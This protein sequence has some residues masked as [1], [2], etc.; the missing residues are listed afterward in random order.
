MQQLEMHRIGRFSL[1]VARR[2]WFDALLKEVLRHD[3]GELIRMALLIGNPANELVLLR[4][5]EFGLSRKR[6]DLGKGSDN[7]RKQKQP[8]FP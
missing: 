1:G 7:E 4:R 5:C 6:R 2:C 8:E 3:A